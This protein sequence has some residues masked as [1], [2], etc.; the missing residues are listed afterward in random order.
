VIQPGDHIADQIL[1]AAIDDQL[2]PDEARAA[3]AHLETCVVCQARLDELR[4]VV[5]L[6][7]ALPAI[8]APRDFSIG[9]RLV[10]D[11]PNVVR[12]R[13]WYG[14]ARAGAASLAAV[15]VFLSAGALYIDSQPIDS[16]VGVSAA[17]APAKSSPAVAVPAVP[18]VES[19]PAPRSAAV[20]APPAPTPAAAAPAPAPVPPRSL[21]APSG[22]G[23]AANGTGPADSAPAPAAPAS[24]AIPAAAAAARS[25]PAPTATGAEVADQV[26]AATSVRPLPT[27]VPTLAPIPTQV[28]QAVAQPLPIARVDSAA[29]LRAAAVS[30]GVLAAVGLLLA[31]VIRHRLRAASI[32]PTE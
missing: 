23:A 22:A 27:L 12:L 21:A 4:S 31:L 28:P 11:P 15:F 3:N 2:T 20:A 26:T 8:E 24:A 9:P 32:S 6:L 17:Q 13:R 1:S 19:A 16:S 5:G 30:V 25:Q 14:V 10:A 7:R 18:A 29:P